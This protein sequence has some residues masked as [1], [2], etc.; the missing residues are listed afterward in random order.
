M[1]LFASCAI[2]YPLPTQESSPYF[3]ARVC[4]IVVDFLLT[5]NNSRIGI[6][7][8][9]NQIYPGKGSSWRDTAKKEEQNQSAG[10]KEKHNVDK[11][12]QLARK[13]SKS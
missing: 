11:L 10:N 8:I 12:G 7:L 4:S 13:A 9:F 5:S 3:Q 6:E 2:V 1:L